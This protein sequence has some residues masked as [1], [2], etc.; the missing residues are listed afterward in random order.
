MTSVELQNYEADPL[1]IPIKSLNSRFQMIQNLGSGSFGIVALYK[2]KNGILDS[3]YE[4]M[5]E[6]PGTL[7]NPSSINYRYSNDLVAIKT[8]NKKLKN[9]K[10]YSNVKEIQFIFSVNSHFN[11]VQILDVFIDRSYLKLHIVM[12]NMDQNL[13]QLMK[14]RKGNVFSPRTLKSILSQLLCAI[15]HIHKHLFFHRDVKPENILVMQN[16]NFFGSRSNIPLNQRNN[17]YIIKLADYGLARHSKN[18]KPFTAYVSTRWYRSPEILFRQGYYSFP[19][20]IWA[21]GC[22]AVECATFCPLF[23][24]ANELDQS[25]KIMEFLGNPNKSFQNQVLQH[26]NLPISNN[27]NTNQHYNSNVNKRVNYNYNY[28]YNHHYSYNNLTPFGGFW[29]EAKDLVTKLGLVFPKNFGYRL[30]NVILRKDFNVHEKTAFFHLVKSC[31]TWDPNKRATAYNLVNCAY[32]QETMAAME[33]QKENELSNVGLKKQNVPSNIPIKPQIGNEKKKTNRNTDNMTR[34]M[35]FAGIQTNNNFENGNTSTKNKGPLIKNNQVIPTQIK[36]DCITTDPHNIK[37]SYPGLGIKNKFELFKTTNLNKND[38]DEK[39][40]SAY[41]GDS[42]D[43]IDDNNSFMQL[44]SDPI[45]DYV[46]IFPNDVNIS[47]MKTD[48]EKDGRNENFE[49]ID[50]SHIDRILNEDNSENEYA[51]DI[52]DYEEE[53]DDNSDQ[54]EEESN[55]STD[56]DS[57]VED[58]ESDEKDNEDD[59]E[60]EPDNENDD[61]LSMELGKVSTFLTDPNTHLKPSDTEISIKNSDTHGNYDL[62]DEINY[63]LDEEYGV[64]HPELYSWQHES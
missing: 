60:T 2:V 38:N 10:D 31:L 34:S 7:L 27:D 47:V 20:D 4:E 11:L 58:E 41:E 55:V 22:V 62:I 52:P 15:L 21:F 6:T 33:N 3:L 12:E 25:C 50:L 49:R 57:G 19:V 37:L 8:M 24:G 36:N 39:I 30:E 1:Q 44:T 64:S 43:Y 5:L 63:A 46:N 53:E 40:E 56:E 45:D 23:P 48:N 35:I 9:I 29:D 42:C 18:T 61:M 59:D 13:Y 54:T 16:L 51:C 14:M 26:Y 28:N 32:F 17:S